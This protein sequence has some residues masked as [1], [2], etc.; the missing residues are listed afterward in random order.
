MGFREVLSDDLAAKRQLIRTNL[1]AHRSPD[2]EQRRP[3]FGAGLAARF[4]SLGDSEL[5]SIGAVAVPKLDQKIVAL[6]ERL[7]RLK[8]QHKQSE[9]RRRTR[10][11]RR[12][13]HDEARRRDLVGAVVLARVEQGLLEKSV[14]RGWPEAGLTDVEDRAL[15]GLPARLRLE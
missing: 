1:S 15:F 2:C 12:S 7:Q 11:S 10:E 8:Q 14:L 6:E 5:R 13:R 9:A 3:I 4:G